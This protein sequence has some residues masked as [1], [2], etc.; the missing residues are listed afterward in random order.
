MAI[1][2]KKRAMSTRPHTGT[3]YRKIASENEGNRLARLLD[4]RTGAQEAMHEARYAM[5]EAETKITKM[6]LSDPRGFEDVIS[7]N[8]AKLYRKFGA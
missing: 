4:D 2:N 8:W 6:V 5:S 1:R 3:V 7:V